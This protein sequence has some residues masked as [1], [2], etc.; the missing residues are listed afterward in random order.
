MNEFHKILN[1]STYARNKGKIFLVM[2][3]VHIYVHIL[4]IN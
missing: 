3:Y 4:T 1:L 2:M